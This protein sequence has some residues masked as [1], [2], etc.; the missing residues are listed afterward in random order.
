[1]PCAM[2]KFLDDRYRYDK[3]EFFFIGELYRRNA[4]FQVQVVPISSALLRTDGKCQGCQAFSMMCCPCIGAFYEKRW[5]KIDW[6]RSRGELQETTLRA[7]T[8]PLLPAANPTASHF[9]ISDT[10]SVQRF[11]Q[12][13]RIQQ[14]L[15]RRLHMRLR[16]FANKRRRYNAQI[17]KKLIT[18]YGKVISRL[19]YF[20]C[21]A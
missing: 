17:L 15:Q 12:H 7:T 21:Q 10:K 11:L 6:I 20:V 8:H 9:W 4:S 18:W 16:N 19:N 1:M 2:T 3:R 5:K 14:Y 13:L